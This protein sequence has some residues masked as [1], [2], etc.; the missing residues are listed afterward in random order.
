MTFFPLGGFLNIL[1]YTRPKVASLRRTH[2]ECS[3]IRGFWMVLH[4]GGEI[5]DEIDLSVSFCHGCCRLP[6]WLESEYEYASGN[7]NMSSFGIRLTSM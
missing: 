2:P 6:A 7:Q 5:P 1:V 3:R 4:A